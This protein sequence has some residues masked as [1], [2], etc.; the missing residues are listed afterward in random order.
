MWDA[1]RISRK[2]NIL[3]KRGSFHDSFAAEKTR[4]SHHDL[5]VIFQAAVFPEHRLDQSDGLVA[6][7]PNALFSR[8]LSGLRRCR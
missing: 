3:D 4:Q 1:I 5:P 7:P 2:Y 6:G 8:H